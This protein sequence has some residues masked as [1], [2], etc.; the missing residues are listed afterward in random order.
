MENSVEKKSV[1]AGI[2]TMSVLYILGQLITVA[3]C[4]INILAKDAINNLLAESGAGGQQATTAQFVITLVISLIIA[5]AVILIL[6]KM[7]IGAFL[8]IGIEVLSL[9]YKLIA[10]GVNI[11][12]LVMLIFPVLMIFFIYKKKDIYFVK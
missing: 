5:I 3:G 10:A 9:I 1:G 6:C 8:F 11:F 4:L 12:T 7:P 2:I